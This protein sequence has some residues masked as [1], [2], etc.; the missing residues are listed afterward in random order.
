MHF[1]GNAFESTDF[2][3]EALSRSAQLDSG[4]SGVAVAGGPQLHYKRKSPRLLDVIASKT[5][6]SL[7]QA[8]P[9]GDFCRF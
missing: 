1:G 3:R 4:D 9:Q 8:I 6:S 7:A 5:Q 2:P